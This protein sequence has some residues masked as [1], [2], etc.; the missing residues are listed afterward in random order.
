MTMFC[1][2]FIFSTKLFLLQTYSR[3]STMINYFI[4]MVNSIQ[5][6]LL[7]YIYYNIAKSLNNWENYQKDYLSKNSLAVKSIMFDLINNYFSVFYIAFLK[8]TQ[9][10]G[11]PIEECIGYEG[12]DSC[13]EEIRI[14]LQTNHLMTFF[15]D[16]MEIGIPFLRQRAVRCGRTTH[17]I[18][19]RTMTGISMT[20]SGIIS[21]AICRIWRMRS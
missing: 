17:R 21:A 11:K 14:H 16:F 3:Y 9:F 4:S 15:F 8:K 19:T 2:Y 5:I 13:F 18:L 12:N 1:V 6:K 10:L 20:Y 7:N